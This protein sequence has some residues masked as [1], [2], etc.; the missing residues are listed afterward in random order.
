MSKIK[1][2][3]EMYFSFDVE[4]DGPFPGDY[5]M[6][7]VG[8]VAC[9][10]YDGVD[11]VRLNPDLKKHQV[12]IEFKPISSKFEQAAVEVC[13]EG[14]IDRDVLLLEGADPRAFIPALEKRIE[15][16]ANGCR[17]VAVA[18]PLGFDWMF[19]YWYMCK[20]GNGKNNPFGFSGCLDIKSMYSAK[21]NAMVI[22]STKRN[23]LN[24]IKSKRAHT[25]N[26]LDDAIEQAEL[27]CN[28]WEM[29]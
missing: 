21:K 23:M 17:P 5:S 8:M 13:K 11:F 26:A 22:N 4:A 16:I 15:E 6:L 19:L 10:V 27:F 9:A 18:Y 7:S 20:Y 12:Y 24:L 14:G 28:I 3:P 1:P 25:H 2:N 29:W